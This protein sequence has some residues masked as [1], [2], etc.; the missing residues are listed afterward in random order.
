MKFSSLLQST[1][2]HYLT[3]PPIPD[4]LCSQPIEPGEVLT[5][6]NGTKREA[7]IW[8]RN[9]GSKEHVKTKALIFPLLSPVFRV[10]TALF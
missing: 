5:E 9:G 6:G 10:A 3:G 4:L 2:H 8:G 1:A 7:G